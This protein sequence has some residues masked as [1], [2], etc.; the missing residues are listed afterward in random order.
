MQTGFDAERVQLHCYSPRHDSHSHAYH[1]VILPLLGTL[2]LETAIGGGTV[3]E[4]DFAVV[5]AGHEHGFRGLGDN[6]FVT[7]DVPAPEA[8]AEVPLWRAASRRLFFPIDERLGGL[9]AFAR[10][11]GEGAFA[12]AGF[13]AGLG[14]LL[15]H[16][17]A[18]ES[19]AP[20]AGADEPAALARA[21]AFVRGHFAEPITVEDMAGAARVSVATLHRLFRARG[22]G[23]PAKYLSAVRLARARALLAGGRLPIAEIALAC[24]YSEQSALSRALRREHGLSPAACRRRA[25]RARS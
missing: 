15:L 21:K 4:R 1:Q 10:G 11:C 12:A 3:G 17:L 18:P 13:R 23:S 8:G 25:G 22:A 14:A 19:V 7:L 24:G 5:A 6:R 2:E 16:G 20:E 9:L